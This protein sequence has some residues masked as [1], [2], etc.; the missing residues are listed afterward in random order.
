MSD[1]RYYAAAF[2]ERSIK[3]FLIV[4]DLSMFHNA[5]RI[6]AEGL[7]VGT[8]VYNLVFDIPDTLPYS[9]KSLDIFL[10][11]IPEDS[12]WFLSRHHAHGSRDFLYALEHGGCVRVGFEDSPFLST[13]HRARSNAELVEEVVRSAESLGRKVVDSRRTREI[14]GIH[15]TKT[16]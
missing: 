8:Q 6:A 11:Q 15:L 12:V 2:K 10:G 1:I 9:P 7:L 4:F 14:L 13:G 5:T 16:G 3:P